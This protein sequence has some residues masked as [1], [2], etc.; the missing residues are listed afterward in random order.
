MLRWT[1]FLMVAG[2]VAC[3]DNTE[4]TSAD[5]HEVTPADQPDLLLVTNLSFAQISA[6]P[7]HSCGRT[8][9]VGKLYCW[10]NNS[11]GQLGD[12]THDPS[13]AGRLLP[14]PVAPPM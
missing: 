13:G 11:S 10:G 7:D 6:G 3:T 5:P 9:T 4:P 2:A 14:V 1:W 12:G 8:M